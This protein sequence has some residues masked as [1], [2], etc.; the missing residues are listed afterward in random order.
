[1]LRL[2]ETIEWVSS[3]SVAIGK[4]TEDAGAHKLTFKDG[5]YLRTRPELC[6]GSDVVVLCRHHSADPPHLQH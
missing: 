3:S 5:R 6:S 2:L 4:T 1:M